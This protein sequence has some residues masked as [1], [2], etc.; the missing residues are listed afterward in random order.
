M[1]YLAIPIFI[2]I[3]HMLSIP[4]AHYHLK[5]TKIGYYY[6][7]LLIYILTT[8]ILAFIQHIYTLI[9]LDN[10]NWNKKTIQIQIEVD[11]IAEETVV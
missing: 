5:N 1:L 2:V 6:L 10:F 7:S 11:N 4:F 8:P 3:L 9:N